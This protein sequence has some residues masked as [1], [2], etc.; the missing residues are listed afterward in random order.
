MKNDPRPEIKD[1]D[2]RDYS[3]K[4]V[5]PHHIPLQREQTTED[6]GRAVVFLVSEDAKNI[7]AQALSVYGDM[8]PG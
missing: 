3:L 2:P 5:A 6:I 8:V 1:M 4:F 7:T